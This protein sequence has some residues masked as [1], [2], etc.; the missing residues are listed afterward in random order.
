MLNFNCTLGSQVAKRRFLTNI[1][2]VKG[3]SKNVVE[4]CEAISNDYTIYYAVY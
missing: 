3:G 2:V 4:V 1:N